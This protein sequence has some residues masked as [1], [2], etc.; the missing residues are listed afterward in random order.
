MFLT[1]R[2]RVLHIHCIMYLVVAHIV[3][4]QYHSQDP[5]YTTY[6]VSCLMIGEDKFESEINCSWLLFFFL[7]TV[8]LQISMQIL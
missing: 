8:I 6:M 7:E 3:Y 4:Q 1:K 2:S 5:L